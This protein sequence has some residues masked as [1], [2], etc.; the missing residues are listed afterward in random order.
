MTTY[1]VSGLPQKDVYSQY[2]EDGIIEKIL[3]DLRIDVKVTCEFGA[4]DGKHFSNT[5]ALGNSAR[6]LVMIEGDPVK[7]LDLEKTAKETGFVKPI[8]RFV[9]P[10]GS[11]RLDSILD[12]FHIGEVDVL[13][14]DI[15]GYDLKIL[16]SLKRR[17]KLI[18]VEYNPTFGVFKEFEGSPGE[19]VGNSFRSI[20]KH[21]EEIGYSLV[22]TTKTNLFFV[23]TGILV[24]AGYVGLDLSVLGILSDIDNATFQI[25]SAYDGRAIPFGRP[26][27]PWDGCRLAKI[28]SHPQWVYG[29]TPTRLQVAYRALRTLSWGELVR[30][31]RKAHSRGWF[32]F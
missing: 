5:F 19:N 13:S 3:E 17:P 24:D 11:D 21:M 23:L 18:V 1:F 12:E 30:G 28:Y 7:F 10:S 20:C 6:Q 29:W 4:W 8:L 2:G 9:Q 32:K 31:V 16:K 25:A 22:A 15:D 14:V 26:T 27:N